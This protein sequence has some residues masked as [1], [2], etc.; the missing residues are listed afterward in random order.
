MLHHQDWIF[1]ACG[2]FNVK[3]GVM[4][5]YQHIL[6]FESTHEIGFLFDCNQQL[7]NMFMGF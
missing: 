7:Q 5:K 3:N 2:F 4:V 1:I 6:V